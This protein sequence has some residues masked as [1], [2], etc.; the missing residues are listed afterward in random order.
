M[1]NIFLI[2][3]DAWSAYAYGLKHTKYVI[4]FSVYV[5]NRLKKKA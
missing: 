1:F 4:I 3:M 5:F 2:L